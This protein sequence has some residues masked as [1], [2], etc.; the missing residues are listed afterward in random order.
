MQDRVGLPVIVE[1]DADSGLWAEARFGAARGYQDV[2]MIAVGT[3]IGAA[4]LIGGDLY[5]GRYGI[6]RRARPLPRGPGRPAVRLRQPRLL[7]AVRQ[8]QRAGGRG[9]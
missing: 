9:P 8:R 4:I 6:A 3:G 1:N 5:H 2:I 7:G